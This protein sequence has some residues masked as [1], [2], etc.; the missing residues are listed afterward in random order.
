MLTRQ[1][2]W[3]TTKCMYT[4]FSGSQVIAKPDIF[5]RFPRIFLLTLI[6]GLAPVNRQ[7]IYLVKMTSQNENISDKT[8]CISSYD[9]QKWSKVDRARLAANF[10]ASIF[11]HRSLFGFSA[12]SLKK[13]KEILSSAQVMQISI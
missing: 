5:T 4:N 10:C 11:F 9:T 8:E 2:V 3:L 12:Y 6:K 1:S 13:T 7:T